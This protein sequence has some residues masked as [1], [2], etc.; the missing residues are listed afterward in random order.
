[1]KRYDSI[2]SATAREIR[3]QP[4]AGAG[5]LSIGAFLASIGQF[6]GFGL[7][8]SEPEGGEGSKRIRLA[9]QN[10]A[11]SRRLSGEVRI[12]DGSRW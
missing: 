3:A 7:F 10:T 2:G 6:C 1:M 4:N 8:R 11:S 12:P 5:A 9:P